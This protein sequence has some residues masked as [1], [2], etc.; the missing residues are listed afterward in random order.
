MAGNHI[1]NA[2]LY[3]FNKASVF[4]EVRFSRPSREEIENLAGENIDNAK[5]YEFVKGL[6]ETYLNTS[7]FLVVY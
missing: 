4:S 1:D 2:E 6:N 7:E 3:E 5:L